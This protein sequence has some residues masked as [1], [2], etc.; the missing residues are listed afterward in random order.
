MSDRPGA[1]VI[2]A[3]FAEPADAEAAVSAL[4]EAGV[5][6]SSIALK[7]GV[8]PD[9]REREG[10]FVWRLLVIIRLWSIAGAIP[11]AAFGLLLAVTI[12]PEGTAGLIVQV[13]CF[14]DD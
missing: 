1:A 12:G 5:S 14:A 4:I 7:H 9:A 11:G 6:P 13:V 8:L 2:I 10:R 3:S